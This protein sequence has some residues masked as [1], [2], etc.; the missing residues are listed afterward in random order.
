M[1]VISLAV[2]LFAMI[3][4]LPIFRRARIDRHRRVKTSARRMP[5]DNIRRNVKY[6]P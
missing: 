2:L 3:G 5:I 6:R 1:S 4:M